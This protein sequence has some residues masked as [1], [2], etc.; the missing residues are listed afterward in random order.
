MNIHLMYKFIFLWL[1]SHPV[2]SEHPKNILAVNI[3]YQKQVSGIYHHLYKPEE[4]I[5]EIGRQLGMVMRVRTGWS[6]DRDKVMSADK[7][8]PKLLIRL[9]DLL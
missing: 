2:W 4:I 7:Y 3:I 6:K 5:T 9:Q 1:E 8:G